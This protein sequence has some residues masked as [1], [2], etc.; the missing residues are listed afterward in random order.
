MQKFRP[1][2]V[3]TVD[4]S[5]PDTKLSLHFESLD[6]PLAGFS[7]GT[8]TIRGDSHPIDALFGCQILGWRIRPLANRD[9]RRDLQRC[10]FQH[11]P[12]RALW[13]ERDHRERENVGKW[14]GRFGMLGR[15]V[16]EP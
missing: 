5:V 13:D 7:S 4:Q 15:I 6:L 16:G 14:N 8:Q 9:F 11:P 2:V 3:S 12:I 1:R 10:G